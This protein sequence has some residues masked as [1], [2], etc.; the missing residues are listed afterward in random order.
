MTRATE[1]QISYIEDL[2]ITREIGSLY[3]DPC[4][5]AVRVGMGDEMTIKQAS[6][7]IEML[8]QCPERKIEP[9]PALP[10]VE[11]TFAVGA[12]V[13]TKKGPGKVTKIEGQII[14]VR[15][16]WKSYS[17]VHASTVKEVSQS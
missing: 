4:A 12:E 14:T 6:E 3:D 16:P 7:F 2:M 15:H 13:K 10:E 8:L 1:R 5:Q 9:R 11:I 17:K